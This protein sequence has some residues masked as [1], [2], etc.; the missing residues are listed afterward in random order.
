MRLLDF[1]KN[2][3]SQ[4]GEDGILSKIF[5]I[6][7]VRDRWCVEFGAWDGQ[8]LSNTFNLIQNAGYSA[9]LMEGSTP[10]FKEMAARFSGN[11]NVIPLNCFV[12]FTAED[13][14]DKILSAT[15]IPKDFDFLSIDI[16]G[17]DYHVWEAMSSYFP[18]VVCVEY[19][20]SIPTEVD[21]VQAADNRI[22]QGASLLALVRLGTQKGYEL[23]GVTSANAI[24]VRAEYFKLFGIEDNDPATLREDTSGVTHIFSGY[25]GTVFFR[26][27][28]ELGWHGIKYSGRIRKLP[29]FFNRYP[30]NFGPVTMMMFRAY[31]KLLRMV[32]R[33]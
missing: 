6:I 22:N 15:P 26:G 3:Y 10:R 21:F 33:A 12:G 31:R 4:T 23:V 24:F 19:N 1:A 8:Y 27:H 2:E 28:G 17:N 32:G 16:D 20:A 18:K 30:G 9:V 14:L 5:E 11:S 13:G 25:D 7:G 29:K